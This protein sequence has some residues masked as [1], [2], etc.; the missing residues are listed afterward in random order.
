MPDIKSQD[1]KTSLDDMII[2]PAASAADTKATKDAGDTGGE[3]SGDQDFGGKTLEVLEK[4][5]KDQKK[6][7]N[8]SSREGVK[9]SKQI[10]DELEPK[11]TKLEEELERRKKY[12]PYNEALEKDPGLVQ[13]INDYYEHP[14]KGSQSDKLEDDFEDFDMKDALTN[15]S[16]G[17]GKLL[18]G[19]V[20]K[21]ME[22]RLKSYDENRTVRDNTVAQ[23]REFLKNHPGMTAKDVD[24][25]IEKS[26]TMPY[27]L[28]DVYLLA[29]RETELKKVADT[30]QLTLLEQM[31]KNQSRP[32]SLAFVPSSGTDR[33][34]E[35]QYFDR[36][37]ELTD[38]TS[39]DS[40]ISKD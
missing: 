5:L 11:I 6:L 4:D 10:K 22:T 24:N 19:V 25:L 26:K 30:A 31:K 2:D 32:P 21:L 34:A 13:A 28:E 36:L 23:K 8:E 17:S 29:N 12:D 39:L 27:T 40:M 14:G 1:K 37:K 18:L 15:P 9:L 20:D 16:S 7:Y 33:P 38:K 35:D 3:P